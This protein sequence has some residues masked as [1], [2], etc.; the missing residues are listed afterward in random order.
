MGIR[1]HPGYHY[2]VAARQTGRPWKHRATK[3]LQPVNAATM[4][5]QLFGLN[6]NCFCYCWMPDN[7]NWLSLNWAVR[8]GYW[9]HHY[10]LA[11][12]IV[13]HQKKFW[14]K[15]TFRLRFRLLFFF[16]NYFFFSTFLLFFF[17]RWNSSTSIT[18]IMECQRKERML[19]VFSFFSCFSIFFLGRLFVPPLCSSTLYPSNS[20]KLTGI[21][22]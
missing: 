8:W 10:S 16:K 7:Y 3:Q 13:K 11:S 4:V 1:Q 6:W 17:P 12:S 18:S 5:A 9:Q 20:K 14:D 15:F 2:K 22:L 19:V 21:F